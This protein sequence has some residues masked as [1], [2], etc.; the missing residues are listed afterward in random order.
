MLSHLMA[1]LGPFIILAFCAV[2]FIEDSYLAGLEKEQ[3]GQARIIASIYLDALGDGTF[4]PESKKKSLGRELARIGEVVGTNVVI[5]G[6]EGEVLAGDAAPGFSMREEIKAARNGNYAR[7]LE[8]DA[9]EKGQYLAA[10]LPIIKNDDIIG[11]IAIRGSTS[12][13]AAEVG[14]LTARLIITATVVILFCMFV[15]YLLSMSISR[16]VRSLENTCARIARGERR[17]ALKGP[18]GAAELKS[19]AGSFRNMLDKLEQ[20]MQYIGDFV[21]NLS[22]EL[23]T[24]ITSIRGAAELLAD[25][26]VHDPE[27]AE[28]FVD[29][30]TRETARLQTLVQDILDLGRLENDSIIM[31]AERI[32]FPLVVENALNSVKMR[33]IA[34]ELELSVDYDE[35]P[36]EVNVDVMWFERVVKNLLTNAIKHTPDGGA[37]NISVRREDG[38]LRTI[39]SDT[40]CGIPDE[41]MTRIFERFY[42]R[43]RGKDKRAPKG[44]GLG[45]AIAKHIVGLHD[46]EIAAANREEGGAE[47]SFT[48]PLAPARAVL[49]EETTE[50]AEAP[51]PVAVG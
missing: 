46:G 47:F 30:I 15:A 37:I 11:V 2:Y 21:H 4:V 45:L 49:A 8:Y 31:K 16:P 28:R 5:L 41:D 12:R 14:R 22:H 13:V 9:D 1:A 38:F 6:R 35:E 48:I 29:N 43:E 10:A 34:R 7:V 36:L 24:P 50:P 42:T 27:A 40:G 33:L 19:L 18:W 23:K 32:E 26:A 20:K 51:E 44:T 25:G 3:V 17:V 39:V